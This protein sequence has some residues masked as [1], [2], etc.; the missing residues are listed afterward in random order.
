MGAKSLE[1]PNVES[2][3]CVSVDGLRWSMAAIP[4]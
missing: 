1:A 4:V 2:S 3:I